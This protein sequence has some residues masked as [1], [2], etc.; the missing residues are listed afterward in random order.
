MV[1]VMLGVD[2][3]RRG[4]GNVGPIGEVAAQ[5]TSAIGTVTRPT[6]LIIEAM[7]VGCFNT[8]PLRLL[9]SRSGQK[10]TSATKLKDQQGA[11]C[12]ARADGSKRRG[13]TDPK[14]GSTVIFPANRPARSATDSLR[15]F[16][17]LPSPRP[18]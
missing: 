11:G 5:T 12:D 6:A 15:G 8:R 14:K 3:D 18:V 16:R 2:A 4:L 1:R 10:S 7:E 9:D 17:P 13:S